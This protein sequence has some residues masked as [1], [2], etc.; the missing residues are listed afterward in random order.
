MAVEQAMH[1]TASGYDLSQEVDWNRVYA[2]QLPRVYNF[3]R[4]RIPNRADVEDLTSR[5]F[6]KAWQSRERY[7]REVALFS[8]WLFTIARNLAIDHLRGARHHLALDAALDVP[9][10]ATPEFVAT[11]DSNMSRLAALTRNLAE[12]ERELI[13]L[14]YG[15]A[16]NNRQIAELTGLSESN[17]GTILS[18]TVGELRARW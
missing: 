1:P 10:D 12:R 13:A 8:T 4:F 18:R 5:T 6:E 3:F 11:E 17:V 7:R 16:L 2:E 14:K 9:A 15:A